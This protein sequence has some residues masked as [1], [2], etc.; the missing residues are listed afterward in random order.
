MDT[1][2]RFILI[3]KRILRELQ[4]L[5]Q[6]VTAG[7]LGVQKQIS[8]IRDE[9][10][11]DKRN[12][13]SDV[14]IPPTRVVINSFPPLTNEEATYHKEKY[15][16]EKIKF[17][18]ECATLVVLAIY[19][20]IALWQ[21]YLIR[22]Q[23]IKDQRPYVWVK[24]DPVVFN[25]EWQSKPGT[26]P[27]SWNVFAVNY[28]KTPAL[29]VVLCQEILV[30][31]IPITQN[32]RL[33]NAEFPAGCTDPANQTIP[34]I[35]PGVIP[36]GEQISTTDTP[37]HSSYYPPELIDLIKSTDDSMAIGGRIDYDD[38]GGN[39][40]QS[41]FCGLRFA[42]GTIHTCPKYQNTIK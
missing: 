16:R 41:F 26:P 25:R 7:F 4:A 8:P 9:Q 6:A 11:A 5:R 28:G 34:T 2:S 36:Q 10:E 17:I 23:F 1:S 13:S 19:T 27:W 14:C 21:A 30:G 29:N 32:D 20:G 33:T 3:A 31:K 35:K 12:Q 40:H 15:P 22:S 37:S 42:S 39:H 38:V 24:F 18:V